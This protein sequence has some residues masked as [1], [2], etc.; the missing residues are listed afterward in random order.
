MIVARLF[1]MGYDPL[2]RADLSAPKNRTVFR[3]KKHNI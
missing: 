3:D 1:G 2:A